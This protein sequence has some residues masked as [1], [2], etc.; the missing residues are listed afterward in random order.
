VRRPRSGP[1][2][3]RGWLLL[4]LLT[5]LLSAWL[6]YHYIARPAW[7]DGLSD[8]SVEALR[9]IELGG[10]LTLAVVLV[11]LYWRAR[12]RAVA[13]T[14]VKSVAELNQLSPEAFELY[15]GGLF[16]LKRYTVVHRGG[17]GDHGVDLELRSPDGRRAI[18]QCK[19]YRNTVGEQ[20][21]RD[22]LGTLIH[23]RAAHAFLATSAEISDAAYAWAA[24]KPITLLD[25]RMLVQIAAELDG[26]AQ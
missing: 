2:Y 3:L 4:A 25:G 1:R 6:A 22:L 26:R 19:R 11:G 10:T 14:G 17:T 23:E 18:V 7:L 16:R 13:P 5:T 20:T 24:G 8:L 9:L 21:V 15:V 12:G